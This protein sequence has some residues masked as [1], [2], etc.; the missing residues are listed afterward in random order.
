MLKGNDF[1]DFLQH[2][3]TQQPAIRF[4]METENDKTILSLDKLFMKDS[5]GRYK[6]LQ[7]HT[8]TD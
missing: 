5:G 3:N 2:V 1:G 6:C 4:T 8:H 7:K